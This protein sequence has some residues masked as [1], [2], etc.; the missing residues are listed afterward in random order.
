[1]IRL[2]RTATLFFLT[3]G[4]LKC[5]LYIDALERLALKKSKEFISLIL[6]MLEIDG[7]EMAIKDNF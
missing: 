4:V 2:I 1:L 6:K 3:R 7:L 5:W